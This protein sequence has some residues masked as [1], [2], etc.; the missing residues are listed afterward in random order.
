VGVAYLYV[1]SYYQ[2]T[3]AERFHLTEYGVLSWLVFRALR[4]DMPRTPAYLTGVLVAGLLG[5][6]DET[7]QWLLPMRVFEWKDIGLN[8]FSSAMGMVVVGLLVHANADR[9]A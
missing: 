4:V 7:V 2:L 3:P 6:G 1:L 9:K 8:V 5:V